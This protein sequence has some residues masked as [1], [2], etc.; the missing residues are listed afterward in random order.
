MKKETT[1]NYL[2]VE[3]TV[4][5]NFEPPEEQVKYYSDMSGYPGSPAEFNIE[6]VMTESGDDIYG[7]FLDNQIED[8]EELCLINLSF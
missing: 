3:L 2:G 5:G 6:K 7:I 4:F 8:I 1:I